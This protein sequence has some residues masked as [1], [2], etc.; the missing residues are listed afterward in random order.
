MDIALNPFRHGGLPANARPDDPRICHDPRDA[1]ALYRQCPAAHETP[2]LERPALART[3]GIHSLFL[4]DER[5][6]MGLGSFKALGAAHAIAKLAAKVGGF[7]FKADHDNTLSGT[8]FVCASAGNHGY[9]M[10]AGARVF[11]ASAVVYLPMAVPEEFAR[12]LADKGARVIREGV[13]Y[14]ASMDAAKRAAK[15]NGWHLLSDSSWPGY[16]EPA[17]DIMEGYLIMAAEAADQIGEPPTHIFLQAGVGGLAAACAALARA[18]WGDAPLISIVEPS[19][20]PALF[21]SIKAG[22]AIVTHGS[23]SSCGERASSTMGGK[24]ASSTMG[25]GRASS[26]MGRLDCKEPSLLALDY[27]AVEADAFM[28]ISDA[29]AFDTVAMLNEHGVATSPSGAAGLAGL[30]HLGADRDTLGI[31]PTSRILVY[32]SEGPVDE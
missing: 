15:T 26:K 11:G 12:R 1:M 14:E 23:T 30:H 22:R 2:L 25:E 17:R 29:Q 19:L 6:R 20:A 10:A 13:N 24:R 9:A 32:I 21:E 31:G 3:L 7:D 4:K 27:L 8:T 18:R 16:T 28:T 5:E